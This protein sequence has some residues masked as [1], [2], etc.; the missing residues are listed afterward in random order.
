MMNEITARK[1]T[2]GNLEEQAMRLYLRDIR[3]T[4]VTPQEL[5][6]SPCMVIDL[7]FHDFDVRTANCFFNREG[8]WDINATRI[9]SVFLKSFV[10][11]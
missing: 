1:L 5:L 3:P 7:P 9:V 10:L 8:N 4:Y 2:I 6:C 11:A